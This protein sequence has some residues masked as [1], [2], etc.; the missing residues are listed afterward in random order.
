MNQL[1]AKVIH[2][3]HVNNLHQL[4]FR[5]KKEVIHMLSLEVDSH[6]KVG[7]KV[8]L[9][10]KPTNVSIAK[11]V[12]GTL[13]FS[14]Q[15]K[16]CIVHVNNGKILSSLSIDVEGFILES[17]ISLHASLE[18]KLEKNDNILVLIEGSNIAIC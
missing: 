12:S 4:K 10:V 3:E 1:I 8:T 14:N 13:S 5:L 11:N 16:G 2:I 7:S 15:L 9:S 6:L 17:L 18:M